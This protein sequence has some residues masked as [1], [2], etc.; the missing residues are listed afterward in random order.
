MRYE[1]LL[2]SRHLSMAQSNEL[3]QRSPVAGFFGE[4]RGRAAEAHQRSVDF[5]LC[6][7]R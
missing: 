2:K 3:L 1:N 5:F 7:Q 4:V 6:I